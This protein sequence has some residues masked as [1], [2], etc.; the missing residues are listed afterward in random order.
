MGIIVVNP[1]SSFNREPFEIWFTRVKRELVRLCGM[2]PD[3]LP[4]WRY[5]ED[6]DARVTPYVSARRAIKNA[7]A[8]L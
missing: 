2:T 4:D 8:T 3:M 7:R 6:Y 1:K 5:R